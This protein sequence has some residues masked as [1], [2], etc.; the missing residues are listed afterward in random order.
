VSG[1][2]SD[3]YLF[4][5]YIPLATTSYADSLLDYALGEAIPTIGWFPPPS[6]L[7]GLVSLP[8]G[9]LA[10]FAGNTVYFS[11]PYYPHAWPIQYALS[12]P[13][14]IVGLG[15]FGSSIAVMTDRYP[16]VIDGGIPGSMS[17]QKVPDLEPCLTKRSIVATQAGIWY[18]SP[19]GI[20]QIGP[21][22]SGVQTTPLFRRDEWQALLPSNI[23][24]TLYD[25]KYFA[26]YPSI[27]SYTPFILSM[28]DTPAMSTI[29]IAANA[30]HVDAQ[31]GNLYYVDPATNTIFQA[32]ADTLNPLNYHWFS[33]RFV[34]PQST[35]FSVIK[36][37]GDFTQQDV[38]LAYDSMIAADKTANAA[39]FSSNL[40]GALN[41]TPLDVYT[42]DGSTMYNIP[43]L[44]SLLTAQ[45]SLWG[46]EELK[47]TM[48]FTDFDCHRIPAFKSK[49]I[50]VEIRGTVSIRS[51]SIATTVQE[52]VA[53]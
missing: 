38:T 34:L 22:G 42:V 43:A 29:D 16:F 53:S 48:S 21:S 33:K 40:L 2:S 25:T 19:N 35:S 46:D 12:L 27:T 26:L 31:N 36:V 9:A 11:E 51:V 32:D 28:D 3:A 24:A 4:V 39:L 18:A 17:V 49:T 44:A 30:V 47:A 10:G 5:A 7:E 41:S 23:I 15:V 8:S 52:M 45:V 14:E 13:H 6:N 50:E 1:S 37:D 20:M